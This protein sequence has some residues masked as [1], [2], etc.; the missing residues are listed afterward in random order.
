LENI[1]EST[2]FEDVVLP[3]RGYLYKTDAGELIIPDGKIRIH[4]MTGKAE[5]ILYGSAGEGKIDALIRLCTTLPGA[6]SPAE[7]TM[8]DRNYILVKLRIL[9][10]GEAYPVRCRCESCREQ[11]AYQ[12]DLS[13]L[14]VNSFGDEA[15]AE[16]FKVTLPLKG[17][18][19]GFR[20]LRGRD[21]EVVR[22]FRRRCQLEGKQ[23]GGGDAYIFSL[24]RRIVSVNG[25][26]SEGAASFDFVENLV[27]RDLTA[28]RHAY[29]EKNVGVNMELKVVCPSCLY[30]SEET[31]PF[32]DEF[33]RPKRRHVPERAF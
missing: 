8:G 18:E 10:L 20:L 14:D 27:S 16:P 22:K 28:F 26:A 31:L 6:L 19:V 4:A 30:E 32:S 12:V 23:E 21:E 1:P 17:C 25:H 29:D 11:F 15:E 5:K 3:S 24:S 7:L 13:R 2:I 9:S 33:F